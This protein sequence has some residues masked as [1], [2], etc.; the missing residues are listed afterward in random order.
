MKIVIVFCQHEIN[1]L[2]TKPPDFKE[3]VVL[4]RQPMNCKNALIMKQY[5]EAFSWTVSQV[6]FT[7]LPAFSFYSF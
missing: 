1:F 4:L 3:N 6:Y 5:P 2:R 7:L